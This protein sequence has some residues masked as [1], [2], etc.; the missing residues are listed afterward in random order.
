MIYEFMNWISVSDVNICDTQ[1]SS[2]VERAS[3]LRF[4]SQQFKL[5]NIFFAKRSSL[6]NVA[7]IVIFEVKS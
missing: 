5:E 2:L 1:I 6:L 7:S 4:G 3:L